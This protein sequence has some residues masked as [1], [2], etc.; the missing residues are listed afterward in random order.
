LYR[1]FEGVT[2]KETK[3]EKIVSTENRGSE[4]GIERENIAGHDAGI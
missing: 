4:H 2:I 1:K 3:K